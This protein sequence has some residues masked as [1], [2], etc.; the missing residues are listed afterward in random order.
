MA[1]CDDRAFAPRSSRRT[2]GGSTACA[3]RSLPR[4]SFGGPCANR[5]SYLVAHALLHTVQDLVVLHRPSLF[6]IDAPAAYGIAVLGAAIAVALVR[7]ERRLGRL[8]N[9]GCI[10]PPIATKS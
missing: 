5:S 9:L 3:R 10:E 8:S 4:K 6:A 7:L 1:L 2:S